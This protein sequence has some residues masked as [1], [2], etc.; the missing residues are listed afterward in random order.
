VCLV[1]LVGDAVELA[2]QYR[3]ITLQRGGPFDIYIGDRHRPV[4]FVAGTGQ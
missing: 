1:C 3:A 2:G 4:G